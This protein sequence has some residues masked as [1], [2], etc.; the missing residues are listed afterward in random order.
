M[1]AGGVTFIW[2][3]FWNIFVYNSP[4]SH[5]RID[6]V[7]KNY[8]MKTVGA[9]AY[10]QVR[11]HTVQVYRQRRERFSKHSVIS[12]CILCCTI[13]KSAINATHCNNK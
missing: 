7:E 5:P 9:V 13:A 3:I 1:A 11:L 8:I 2:W 6:P 4:E 12:W 10:E